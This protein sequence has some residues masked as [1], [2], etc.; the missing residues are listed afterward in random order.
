MCVLSDY[1]VHS[2]TSLFLL[3]TLDS[4]RFDTATRSY[5]LSLQRRS[6]ARSRAIT[7]RYHGNQ[8]SLVRHHSTT[9]H[10]P[11]YVSRS[12][13]A[14]SSLYK[15]LD[16]ERN[17]GQEGPSRRGYH[18]NRG[19]LMDDAE[20]DGYDPDDYCEGGLMRSSSFAL[21]RPHISSRVAAR[22]YWYEEETDKRGHFRPPVL[23]RTCR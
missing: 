19:G 9:L 14:R 12:Q 22:V 21:A 4:G 6:R 20:D 7:G 23:S 2:V 5:S 18:D 16:Y 17:R 10:P 1:Q 15:P 13:S 3:Q 11:R 8:P